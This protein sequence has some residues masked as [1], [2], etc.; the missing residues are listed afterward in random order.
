MPGCH[1]G[2][3]AA[4]PL[5]EQG[6]G[7][8]CTC[9]A[10]ALLLPAASRKQWARWPSLSRLVRSHWSIRTVHPVTVAVYGSGGKAGNIRFELI[11]ETLPIAFETG[12]I[13]AQNEHGRATL[14]ALTMRWEAGGSQLLVNLG[15]LSWRAV[16]A[17][18]LKC[19][20]ESCSAQCPAQPGSDQESWALPSAPLLNC[21]VTLH[22]PSQEHPLISTSCNF[23]RSGYVGP[24]CSL[25]VLPLALD[26]HCSRTWAFKGSLSPCNKMHHFSANMRG[27]ER[28][29]ARSAFLAAWVCVYMCLG[30][31]VRW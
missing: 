2:W 5:C 20:M 26:S 6:P 1:A 7:D 9:W 27:N 24:Q 11:R 15:S 31:A 12:N 23:W 19:V 13:C 28:L 8:C 30:S 16:L 22:I 10:L 21:W 14:Y 4:L 18:P 29:S 25:G 17:C 3:A